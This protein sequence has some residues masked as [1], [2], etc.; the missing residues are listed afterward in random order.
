MHWHHRSVLA[1]QSKI[2]SD[3]HQACRG[4]YTAT[5]FLAATS[6]DGASVPGTSGHSG[7]SVIGSSGTMASNTGAAIAGANLFVVQIANSCSHC[8]STVNRAFTVLHGCV[9]RRK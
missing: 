8:K 2:Y 1:A 9:D 5:E 3:N 6:G 4:E 7:A